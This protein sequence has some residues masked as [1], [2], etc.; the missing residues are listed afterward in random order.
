[1]VSKIAEQTNEEKQPLENGNIKENDEDEGES[2]EEELGLYMLMLSKRV[3]SPV[4]LAHI[5]I[6]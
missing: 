5:G 2:S 6:E 3:F 1:M 4:T